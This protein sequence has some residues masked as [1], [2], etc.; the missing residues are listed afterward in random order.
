MDAADDWIAGRVAKGD[1]VVTAD[2]PLASRGVKAGA[3]VI[4]PNGKPFD[5]NSIGMTVAT[6]NLLH[7]LAQRRR[8][9]RRAEA[10]RAARPLAV[11]LSPRSGHRAAEARRGGAVICATFRREG[12]ER[13]LSRPARA[14]GSSVD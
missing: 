14:A 4:A 13:A 6:R 11:S 10:V 5:D 12:V 1:I 8:D 7:E 2:V 9:H 3:V